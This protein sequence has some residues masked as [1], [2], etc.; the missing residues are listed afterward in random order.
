MKLSH[1][2]LHALLLAALCLS[3]SACGGRKPA[4]APNYSPA[5]IIQAV[6]ASQPDLPDLHSL[7]PED[8]DFAAYL[9]GYYGL[10][11]QLVED[12][13]IC[14]AGGVEASEMAVLLL[15]SEDGAAQAREALLEYI[16]ARAA[17]FTGYVPEQAALAEQGEVATQ[18]RYAALFICPEPEQA[19]SAFLAYL[20][21]GPE[22]TQTALPVQPEGAPSEENKGSSAPSDPDS[23]DPQ[24]VLAAW[25]TGDCSQLSEKN[26]IILDRAA[27]VLEEVVWADMSDYEKELALH[28][29]MAA[30]GDYDPGALS[31]S[32]LDRADPDNDNPYGFLVNQ[33]GICL[34]YAT[35]FQL[36]MDLLNIPCV[37]VEGTAHGGTADHAWNMVCLDGEWYCVD[38]TW[39]DPV[40]SSRVSHQYFNVT[41]EYLRACDHQWDA[42]TVEEAKGTLYAWTGR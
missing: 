31:H 26:Q 13:I 30:W 40:G 8:E 6:I 18:G 37:T 10:S 25:Q 27:A 4:Q 19:Q 3:L 21:S 38:V 24:A 42:S 28:D 16:D 1:R 33:K 17:A 35:T 11:S 15:R 23:Y 20:E 5:E 7:T 14:Y 36:F 9:E 12:G 41:S 29:W 39:D 22:G 2:I 34:G 32:A